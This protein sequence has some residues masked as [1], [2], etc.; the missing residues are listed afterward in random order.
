MAGPVATVLIPE[1]LSDSGRAA[2][3]E[4]VD[5]VSVHDPDEPPVLGAFWVRDTAPIEGGYSGEGRPFAIETGL[6]PDWEPGQLAAVAEAFGCA[7]R[8]E[9][10]VIA[11]CNGREDHR[12]L[13]ELCLRLADRFGGVICFGG[14]LWPDVPPEAGFDILDADWPR[15]EPYFRR[16]V[17]GVPGRVVGLRH[18]R[19]SGGEWVVHV[20]D[21]SF[22]RAWLEHPQFRMVK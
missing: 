19:A 21:A 13:G 7:P 17:A 16:M 9:L 14:A 8:D 18:E 11:F 4:M 10:V 20:G 3:G 1:P 2:I 6:Q 12:I 5:A 15:V 22:L